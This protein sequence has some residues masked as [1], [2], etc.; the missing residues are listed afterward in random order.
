MNVDESQHIEGKGA[1]GV[2]AQTKKPRPGFVFLL[3]VVSVVAAIGWFIYKGISARVSA[4]AAVDRETKRAAILTVSVVQPEISGAS[5]ELIL[6]GNTQ[7]LIDAPIYARTNGYLKRWYADIGT[8]VHAGQL[9]AEVEAPEVDHELQQARADMAT[10][11]ANL[12]LAQ[13]TAARWQFLLKTQSV[14][15]QETDQKIGDMNARKAMVDSAASNVKRLEDIQSYQKVYAPFDGVVTARNTDVGALIGAGSNT[16]AR[17]LF[18][19]AAIN[20]LRVFIRVPEEYGRTARNGM[21]ATLTLNAFPGRSFT[22]TVVR[23]AN[24]IDL[25]SRTLLVEVDVNNPTGEL[26]PGAYAS[27]HL[28]MAG[29]SARALTIPANTLLFRSEGLRVAVVRDGKV[30]LTPIKIGRDFGES[31]EVLAGLTRED[32]LILNAPDSIVSGAAVR[33]VEGTR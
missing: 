27:V 20:R 4:D 23:N 11:Q 25:E 1:V 8:R 3:V 33:I 13:T 14:S 30:Q 6:P 21:R 29:Q 26:L 16:T 12:Q 24:A 10:A 7:A 5:Q 18:H 17:E 15:Q 32:K 28:N 19:V 31:L 22:G 2:P 9:L